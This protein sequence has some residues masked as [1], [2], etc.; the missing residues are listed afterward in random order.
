M[1]SALEA[2][3]AL[4]GAVLYENAALARI[5]DPVTPESFGTAMHGRAWE[6]ATRLIGA[7]RLAEPT[8]IHARMGDDPDLMASGGLT[9]LLDLVEKAPPITQ[10]ADF[11][12]R[13]NEAARRR[14]IIRIAG[15]AM[16]AARDPEREPFAVLTETEAALSALTV[17]AAPDGHTLVDARTAAV[18]LV[19]RLDEEAESGVMHGTLVGLDCIDRQLGGIY[20]NE[21]II[22]AGRPSMGKTALARGIAFGAARRNP[23]K[24]VPFFAL[25]VDRDQLSKRNLSQVSYERGAGIPYRQMKS[26]RDLPPEDRA[27]MDDLAKRLPQNLLIDD[28]AVLTLEHVR[29][30][31]MAL[32][33]RAPLALVVIDYLQI[34]DLPF[35][36]GVNMTTA[37]GQVTKGL[38]QLSKQIGC[39]IILLSQLSRKCEERDNKRPM[40]SDLRDSGSIEQDASSVLFAYRDVYYLEREGPRKGVTRDDHD[41]A[42]QSA[43]RT[44]EVICAKSREGP[45]GTTKQRY[46]A[47][48]DVVENEGQAYG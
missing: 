15:E 43:Y 28:T 17:A 16:Q 23:D 14:E 40:L 45:I 33:R 21:L 30:R 19:A 42:V 32:R 20:P 1:P 38:K 26:G 9:Y 25:E 4:L 7:G 24:L 48:C 6:I 36:Q 3:Q 34:M 39:G 47:E 44:M 46:I 22:L 18:S 27:I 2:E 29:R 37:I 8:A 13:V 10:V 35:W 12:I 5:T 31:C 41:M 11:A